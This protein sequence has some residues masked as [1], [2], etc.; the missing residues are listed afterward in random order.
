MRPVFPFLTAGH[1]GHFV[2]N[3]CLV[4]VEGIGHIPFPS[5]VS[6]LDFQ[7]LDPGQ[8]TINWKSERDTLGKTKS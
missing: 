7:L 8:E 4:A 6:R 2:S 5:L 3:S 1:I